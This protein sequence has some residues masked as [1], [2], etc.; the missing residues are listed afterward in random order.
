MHVRTVKARILLLLMLAA[1][2]ASGGCFL[3]GGGA[4]G[5][6]LDQTT[7]PTPEDQIYS[8][9]PQ[10]LNLE[11]M[12]DRASTYYYF[13]ELDLSEAALQNLTASIEDLR[14]LRPDPDLCDHLDYLETRALCIRQRMED[15]RIEGEASCMLAAA[16][17]SITRTTVVEEEIP[18]EMNQK[19]QHW[20]AYFQGKGRR[21]FAKWLVR[22]GE[23]R[24]I[25]EPILV[26]VGVPRDLLY[27]SV[28]ESGLNLNA[29]SHMRAIGPWQFMAGT[30]RLFGLR[31]NW[32]IDERRDIIASTYAAA[33]YMKYLYDI[34]GS[35]QLA[36]AAYNA[37]EHRVAY[38]MMQQRTNNYWRLRLPVQTSWFVP[39]FMAALAIGRDPENYGFEKPASNPLLFDLI[40][41]DC[42]TELKDIAAAA[43]SS[44]SDIRELNPHFKKWTTPP[45]MVVEV[46][47]PKGSGEQ[48][49]A[50]L[51]GMPHRKLVSYIQHKVKK[52]ETL[53]QIGATYEVSAEEL[54][55][56]NEMKSARSLHAGNILIIPVKDRSRPV[57]VATRPTY[58]TPPPRTA[59]IVL[60]K[61]DG[62]ADADASAPE[63]DDLD[64]E[65]SSAAPP[66]AE[67]A[68]Y[69]VHV[70]RRG[71]TL[72]S[73]GRQ[74][75]KSVAEILALNRSV[76]RNRIHPGDKL[77]IP[78]GSN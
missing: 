64:E 52:G 27:L 78:S 58:R 3:A 54:K 22:T 57:S 47:V 5:I 4:S 44:L 29:R 26:E 65:V 51:A 55:R 70:V 71:E 50:R 36:L 75:G 30:A 13:G 69:V 39:K 35:W 45:D 33:N 66:D 11:R 10:I 15:N 77:R 43:G 31:N 38:A 49:L 7:Q 24:D 9:Y 56:V 76:A 61:L 25:I 21:H 63:S 14:S 68:A 41:V 6:S 74:Y 1:A 37:G 40:E 18:V 23:Y 48:C 62:I 59:E 73:I 17:D 19:T 42:A 67:G 20:L 34:F 2:A 8:R 46:K 32:W 28:I 12:L 60:P 72:S 16:L 53:S